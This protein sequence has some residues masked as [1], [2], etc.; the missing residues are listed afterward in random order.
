MDIPVLL[1]IR[2]EQ[3]YEGQKADMIEL[4][5]DGILRSTAENTWMITYEESALTGLEGVQTNFLIRPNKVRLERSGSL[6]SIMEFEENVRHD[7]LYQM[8]FGALMIGI[9]ARRIDHEIHHEGGWLDVLY[10]IQI[11]QNQAGS[12]L[13][14]IDIQAKA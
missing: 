1:T 7:S 6:Q 10:D 2:S 12:V 9:T 14:H 5:T 13:Y 11:E 8:D 3:R 4:T